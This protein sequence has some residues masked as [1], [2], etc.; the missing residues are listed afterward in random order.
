MAIVGSRLS[1]VR[2]VRLRGSSSIS[3]LQL[4]TSTGSISVSASNIGQT[5]AVISRGNTS[6]L[7]LGRCGSSCDFDTEEIK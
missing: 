4:T 2:G 1:S 5:S 3:T 6:G 7:C